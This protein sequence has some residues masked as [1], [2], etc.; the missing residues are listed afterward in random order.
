LCIKN[1]GLDV[2]QISKFAPEGGDLRKMFSSI[3][4]P[5][6]INYV[7]KNCNAALQIG[8]AYLE[9]DDNGYKYGISGFSHTKAKRIALTKILIG[10]EPRYV[11]IQVAAEMNPFDFMALIVRVMEEKYKGNAE[12]KW[13]VGLQSGIY[14]SG[15]ELFV[16]DIRYSLGETTVPSGSFLIFR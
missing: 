15:V 11:I 5:R 8:P 7:R 4:K 10:S 1:D 9:P 2:R 6:I 14:L 3:I 13:S 16:D 12:I